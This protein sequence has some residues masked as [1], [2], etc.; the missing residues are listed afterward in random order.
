V[1]QFAYQKKCPYIVPLFKTSNANMRNAASI[2]LMLGL[3]SG[4]YSCKKTIN[5]ETQI[6][7]KVVFVSSLSSMKVP[8]TA[9]MVRKF[10]KQSG[11]SQLSEIFLPIPLLKVGASDRSMEFPYK[12]TETYDYN[13]EITLLPSGRVYFFSDINHENNTSKTHY[14]TNGTSYKTSGTNGAFPTTDST[15]TVYGNPYAATP[16]FEPNIFVEYF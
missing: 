3:A 7:K 6:I 2:V 16:Y 11:F 1:S 13:W 9:A 12:G 14:C 8:D 15:V 10:N 5:C 4:L